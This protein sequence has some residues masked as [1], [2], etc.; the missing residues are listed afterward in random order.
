MITE[1]LSQ[2]KAGSTPPAGRRRTLGQSMVE[3]ALI[4]PVLLLMIFGIIEFARIFYS[5]LIVTNAVRTGERYA[6]TGEYMDKYC[7]D[8]NSL[9]G[10]A[11]AQECEDETHKQAGTGRE[12]RNI[13]EDYARLLSIIEITNNAAVGLLTGTDRD[14]PTAPTLLYKESGYFHVVVCSTRAGYLY[15]KMNSAHDCYCDP[16]DDAGNPEEGM[17]KVLVAVTFEHPLI[18]PLIASAWPHVTLHA[19]R[20]GYLEQYRV[21]R[22]LGL[23]PPGMHEP[24]NT[25]TE[26]YTPSLTYT[27]TDTPTVTIT[28][29]PTE[30]ETPTQTSTPTNSLTSTISPTN[31]A[32]PTTTSTPTLRRSLTLTPTSTNTATITYTPSITS[33]RTRTYTPSIT[34]TPSITYTPSITRTRTSTRTATTTFTTTRTFT[35]TQTFTVTRTP[36]ITLTPTRTLTRTPV[37][38][39]ATPTRTSTNTPVTPT[40]TRTR[41]LTSTPVTPTLTRTR[42]LTS[43]PVTPTLT[44]TQTPVTPS[45]T[46]TRTSTLTPVTPSRTPTRTSTPVTPTITSTVTRTETRTATQTLQFTYTASPSRSKTP[47]TIIGGG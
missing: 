1:L 19:E 38:P 45:A 35:V 13:E 26:T 2:L 25:F 43:T 10:D 4:L 11:D 34:F 22:V 21:A 36:T 3:F 20:I 31:T 8:A 23:P 17:V 44:R 42:T 41:T 28:P 16:A 33:T 37:T 46:P 47:V 39:S 18:M 32:S 6:V 27:F 15:F 12:Y 30:T 14:F 29:T 9:V 7:D 5:W 24:T 40:A